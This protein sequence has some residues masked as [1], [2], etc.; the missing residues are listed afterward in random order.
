LLAQNLDLLV[1][2][3]ITIRTATLAEQKV[4]EVL[5]L[6]ASLT[7][8]GDRD[9]L[10]ANPDAIEIPLEQIA[11]GRVFV[12]EMDGATVG[13]SAIEPRADGETELDA[14]FVEPTIRRRGVGRLLVDY[15]AEVARKQGSQALHVTGNPHAEDFYLACGFEQIGTVETRFG[16]GLLM[17]KEL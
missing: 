10:L 12:S 1:T 9:A 16:V 5:Q 3:E 7:N 17:R 15:C 8:A 4:L 13:F 2:S 14:L 11:G 6:R